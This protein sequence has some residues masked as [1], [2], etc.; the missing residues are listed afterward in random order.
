MSLEVASTFQ[1]AVG[2]CSSVLK[3]LKAR[4][5]SV[6]HEQLLVSSPGF[7]ILDSGC[8]KTIIGRDT[9]EEFKKLWTNQNV[10]SP[11]PFAETSHFR[12]GNGARE[13]SYEAVKLPVVIAGRS[14]TIHAAL[15]QGR[16][17]LLISRRALQALEAKIDF[18]RGEL[19]VFSGTGRAFANK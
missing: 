5:Q 15:V 1:S 6:V 19:R 12:F 17:P 10:P 3:R 4:S 7:G 14:G 9:F 18:C 13:T 11:T 16:A 2:L 8:G